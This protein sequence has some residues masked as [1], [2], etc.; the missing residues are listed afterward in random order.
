MDRGLSESATPLRTKISKQTIY[1]FRKSR[2]LVQKSWPSRWPQS[3]AAASSFLPAVMAR[4]LP[5]IRAADR[6]DY[7]SSVSFTPS[8]ASFTLSPLVTG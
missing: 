2:N 5:R 4:M 1:Q 3:L 7:F 6:L 8:P